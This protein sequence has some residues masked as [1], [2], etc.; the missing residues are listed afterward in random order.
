MWLNLAGMSLS[1]PSLRAVLTIG[2]AVAAAAWLAAD[3]AESEEPATSTVT[4]GGLSVPLASTVPASER[5]HVAVIVLE[6]KEYGQVIGN[7]AAPYLNS[8]ARRYALATR[9]YG[10]T[11]PSLPNYLALSAGSTF[12]VRHDCTGCSFGG[13][14]LL[15]QLGSAGIS[16]K[17]YVA[18][19]PNSCY[20]ES[21][22][23]G[24]VKPLNPFAYLRRVA[25]RPGSCSNLVPLSNLSTDLQ[26]GNLPDFS[27]IT[28][29]LCQDT[30]HCGV[31]AGDRFMAKLVP[32]LLRGLG[33]HGALFILWDEGRS[34]HGLGGTLGGGH[35]PAIVVGPEVRRGARITTAMD[36][37]ATLRELESVFGV[38]PL[39]HARSV[40][41]D[42]LNSVFTRTLRI[43]SATPLPE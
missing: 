10:V 15:T 38:P 7:P 31:G 18:G 42:P 39:R 24:Y 33:P 28:P 32:P 40:H 2:L 22:A 36:Q 6:N 4:V 21:R 13:P 11:H 3:V 37:Y 35:V 27:W 19:V 16:W 30:H 26:A 12:G 5:S 29:S 17:S 23:A 8:L 20:L 14:N 43:R 41:P 1:T 25:G 9:Y 34:N